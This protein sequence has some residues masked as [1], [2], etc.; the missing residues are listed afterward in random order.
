MKGELLKRRPF[1]PNF[2]NRDLYIWQWSQF[3]YQSQLLLAERKQK[4]KAETHKTIPCQAW[5]DTGRCNYGKRCKFAHGP[6]E[7]RPMP[8]AEVKVFNNP[9]YRTALCIKYTTFGYCPYGDQ[10]HFIHDPVQIDLEKCL[11]WLSGSSLSSS[12]LT[13]E[14]TNDCLDKTSSRTESETTHLEKRRK[15]SRSKSNLESEC[16]KTRSKICRETEFVPLIE[17]IPVNN[18]VEATTAYDPFRSGKICDE[19]IELK[20]LQ[21]NAFDDFLYVINPQSVLPKKQ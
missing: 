21:F 1:D 16:L 6:E 4:R 3:V 8:K 14:Q 12:Q 18:A 7:L 13:S 9:R 2:Y 5:Q 17:S 15:R 19:E 11:D 20:P 10:C